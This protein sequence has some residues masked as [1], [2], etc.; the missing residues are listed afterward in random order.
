MTARLGTKLATL[1]DR[2]RN[3]GPVMEGGDDRAPHLGLVITEAAGAGDLPIPTRHD[4]L[5]HTES[6]LNEAVATRFVPA[7]GI[8]FDPIDIITVIEKHRRADERHARLPFV[9]E[10]CACTWRGTNHDE[11]LAEMI[12]ALARPVREVIRETLTAAELR[13]FGAY[14]IDPK[15]GI[16][17]AEFRQRLWDTPGVLG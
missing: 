10:G 9:T 7:E 17:N 6:L 2:I 16:K 8:A 1:L 15:T 12:T 14:I 11:H 5:V 3:T 13:M 4:E